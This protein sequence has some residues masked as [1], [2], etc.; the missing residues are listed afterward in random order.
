MRPSTPTRGRRGR[1]DL[2]GFE[3]FSQAAYCRVVGQGYAL[4]AEAGD[5]P[6]DAFAKASV[7]WR[8]IA[9]YQQPE[10][11][12]R[13]VA[14]N[15]APPTPAGRAAGWWRWRAVAHRHTCRRCRRI[16]WSC[17]VRWGGWRHG[18]REVLVLR[19]VAELSV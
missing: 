10:A 1:G 16:G 7:H 14:V 4:L 3:A 6:Q 15:Q 12:V 17:V 9:A 5:V 11:W 13:R 2:D 19:Y 8:R 18:T